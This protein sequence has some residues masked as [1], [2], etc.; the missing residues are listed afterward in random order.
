MFIS[1]LQDYCSINLVIKLYLLVVNVMCNENNLRELIQHLFS[2]V[3]IR[4]TFVL[5]GNGVYKLIFRCSNAWLSS[6]LLTI[7]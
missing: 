6:N 2:D 5:L 7:R 3:A 4:I 1:N